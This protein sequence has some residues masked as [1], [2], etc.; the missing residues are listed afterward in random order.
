MMRGKCTTPYR[1]ACFK[2]SVSCFACVTSGWSCVTKG[3]APHC[4]V[5]TPS[6][7]VFI[8]LSGQSDSI[9]ASYYSPCLTRCLDHCQHNMHRPFIFLTLVFHQLFPPS[10]PFALFS[11]YGPWRMCNKHHLNK[12]TTIW[13]LNV[14]SN[15]FLFSDNISKAK[16]RFS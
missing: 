1:D 7:F 14:I 4:V 11:L 8:N 3:G 15:P 13:L 9:H 2:G 10:L 5:L 12:S 16:S 6:H